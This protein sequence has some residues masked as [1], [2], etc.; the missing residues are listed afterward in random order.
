M[1]VPGRVDEGTLIGPKSRRPFPRAASQ[2]G[3]NKP[4]LDWLSA[5]HFRVLLHIDSA[6][7]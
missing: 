2:N 3:D 6:L 7:H 5:K 4:D 1:E